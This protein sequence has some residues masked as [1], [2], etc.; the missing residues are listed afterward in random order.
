MNRLHGP[1]P[2]CARKRSRRAAVAGMVVF[3]A[4]MLAACKDGAMPTHTGPGLQAALEEAGKPMAASAVAAEA[5]QPGQ[6]LQGTITLDVGDGARRY[7]VIATRLADDLGKQAAAHLGSAD[8]KAALDNANARA[9]GKTTVAASDV[10]ELADAFAGKTMYSAEVRTV[11]IVKRQHVS[12]EGEA[13]D[14]SRVTLG[15]SL[16]IGGD[17][18]LDASLAYRP[19]KQRATEDFGAKSRDGT[20]QVALEYLQRGSAQAWS[21][22]GTFE[23]TNLQPGVL[24]KK[25]A[26][27]SIARAAGRFDVAE[28]HVRAP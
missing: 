27:R 9:G 5:L 19:D 24:A 22:A 26:G 18:V 16:P 4:A 21:L 10:Q 23:A 13:A 8:G 12:I 14:G 20:M 6:R 11:D 3:A 1:V 15:F 17:D 2:G 25:L 28:L 7:R